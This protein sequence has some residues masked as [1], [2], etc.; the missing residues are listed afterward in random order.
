MNKVYGIGLPRTGTSSLAVALKNIGYT[1]RHFCVLHDSEHLAYD[2]PYITVLIDNA[3]YLKCKET[4]KQILLT[5]D[6]D[7]LF[8]LTTRSSTDWYNSISKFYKVPNNLPDID[9]YEKLIRSVFRSLNKEDNLLVINVFEDFKCLE[10]ICDFIQV[11]H[12]DITFPHIKKEHGPDLNS[13]LEE[14]IV[15]TKIY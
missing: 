7:S 6:K 3:F 8:I 14:Q 11:P 12:Q 4:I 9:V 10:K 1:T 15:L 2:D 5:Q 13:I